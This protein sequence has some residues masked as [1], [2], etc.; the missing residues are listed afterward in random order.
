VWPRFSFTSRKSSP[1]LAVLV[2]QPGGAFT[3]TWTCPSA[4]DAAHKPRGPS[5]A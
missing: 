5:A 4:F 2:R 3:L 1:L